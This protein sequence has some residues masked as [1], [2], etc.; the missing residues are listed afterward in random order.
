MFASRLC[1]LF[2]FLVTLIS[3]Q[4][5]FGAFEPLDHLWV[6]PSDIRNGT[7]A[8]GSAYWQQQ[9]D[10]QMEVVLDPTQ[11]VIRGKAIITYHNNS[12]EE[13]KYLWLELY[14]NAISKSSKAYCRTH[15][16]LEEDHTKEQIDNIYLFD[17]VGK[18]QIKELVDINSN[19]LS[20]HIEESNMRVD[21]E[22]PISAESIFEFEIQWEVNIP[23][24]LMAHSGY[25][26][27]KENDNYVFAIAQFY[28]RLHFYDLVHGWQHKPYL[29]TGEF[30]SHFGDFDVKISVP[31]NHVTQATGSLMNKQEVL[32]ELQLNRLEHAYTS[33]KPVAIIS[34]LEASENEGKEIEGQKTYHFVAQ[35]V[36]DFMFVSSPKFIWEARILHKQNGK[37]LVSSF[38]PLSAQALWE[39][40][41]VNIAAHTINTYSN[42]TGLDYPYPQLSIVNIENSA[43]EYP[44]IGLIGGRTKSKDNIDPEYRNQIYETIVHEVGHN[45]FPMIVNSDER[46]WM[47]M[48]EGLNTFLMQ[49]AISDYD[50]NWF[51][52]AANLDVLPALLTE[53]QSGKHSTIMTEA[54]NLH[55]VL[56]DAYGKPSIALRTLRDYIIGPEAFD[57]AFKTYVDRWAFKHPIPEDF[58][59][60]MEDASGTDLDWFWRTWFYENRHVD[61]SLAN[62]RV[63]NI[64]Q[65]DLASFQHSLRSD[66]VEKIQKE[67]FLYEI[68]FENLGGALQKLDLLFTF[69]NGDSQLIS[70]PPEIWRK[71]EKSFVKIFPFASEVTEIKIDPDHKSADIDYSNNHWTKGSQ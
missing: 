50:K 14:Q 18:M 6:S 13:L 56:M 16:M 30:A 9:V 24:I 35:K 19:P 54:D 46:N 61:I 38:Y 59:R 27:F 69:E 1:L 68:R 39:S 34:A 11:K 42:Y 51:T 66:Q 47:W 58:F 3:A 25:E 52:L 5:Q 21:L 12:P 62:V 4:D 23:D 32:S 70:L 71:N 26:Y 49:R 20:Y 60:T 33:E 7:G 29:G 64:S 31:K 53:E 45:Y 40:E 37:V 17:H 41:A 2:S 28:P 10:Y 44:M 67:P 48:D 36:R 63:I 57:F 55:N 65:D 15:A 22:T 8:P 43:M